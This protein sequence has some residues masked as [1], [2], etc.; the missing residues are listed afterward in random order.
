MTQPFFPTEWR[1]TFRTAPTDLFDKALEEERTPTQQFLRF[2][3][4]VFP[5]GASSSPTG[6]ARELTGPARAAALGMAPQMARAYQL[7]QPYTGDPLP[8]GGFAGGMT[9]EDYLQANRMP[10][11]QAQ[12]AGLRN[13]MNI[14]SDPTTWRERE[15]RPAADEILAAQ[16]RQLLERFQGAESQ[17]EAALNP[18]LSQVA[19]SMRSN[20]RTAFDPYLESYEAQAIGTQQDPGS[21]F[22]YLQ[23]RLGEGGVGRVFGFNPLT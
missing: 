8:G 10:T 11:A 19:P 9:F 23:N 18:F 13:I 14:A 5:H 7:T 1:P 12:Q 21:F 6:S 17:F 22:R 20:F 3:S 2:L 15:G 16:Q 4:Q